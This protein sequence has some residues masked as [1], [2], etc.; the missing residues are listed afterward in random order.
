MRIPDLSIIPHQREKILE[1]LNLVIR[2]RG[3]RP[4]Q[5]DQQIID[6]IILCIIQRRHLRQQ[7]QPPRLL[8]NIKTI[9]FRKIIHQRKTHILPSLHPFPHLLRYKMIFKHINSQCI[10]FPSQPEHLKVFIIQIDKIPVFIIQLYPD[11][12]ILIYITQQ[13]FTPVQRLVG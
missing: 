13:T 6:Q 7:I 12:D 9:Q 3:F 4:V 10:L 11:R 1:L 8:R 2:L 5:T